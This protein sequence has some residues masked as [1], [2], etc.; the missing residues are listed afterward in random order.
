MALYS[1]KIY[2]K[3]PHFLSFALR[4]HDMPN[5]LA[6]LPIE[7]LCE[8][9]K[10]L[11]FDD[12]RNFLSC[13]S[14]IHESGKH[15]FNEKC[16]RVLPV[17][18]SREG[19]LMAKELVTMESSCF[20]QKIF[21]K[22]EEFKDTNF[23]EY[24]THLEYIL[25]S[26]IQAS[27]KFNTI[28]IHYE[29]SDDPGLVDPFPTAII[30]RALS[31]TLERQ[32]NTDLRIQLQNIKLDDCR[33]LAR[34]GHSFLYRVSSLEIQI[35]DTDDPRSFKWLTP[36]A[37]NLAE[38]S[39][40]NDAGPRFV[41]ISAI[42]K[43]MSKINSG[44]IESISISGM[45]VYGD[46]LTRILRP[47]IPSLKKLQLRQIYFQRKSFETFIHFI[48]GNFTLNNFSLSLEDI[49]REDHQGLYEIHDPM[50]YWSNP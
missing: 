14:S 45:C 48:S 28:I 16:F 4:N 2:F 18:L 40:I 3:R 12:A 36:V 43:M 22:M 44:T 8:V 21:I 10:V 31:T 30:A 13:C 29:S 9:V 6:T 1:V 17:S 26:A 25:T 50:S 49:W 19:L 23:V 38:F 41:T 32:K 24:V 37:K 15:A 35:Q 46:K 11:P 20:I 33:T 27:T 34:F 5:S 47:L 7:L 39:V 42:L